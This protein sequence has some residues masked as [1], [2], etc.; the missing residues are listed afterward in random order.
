MVIVTRMFSSEDFL[1]NPFLS[2][3]HLLQQSN[4]RLKAVTNW[5]MC[6]DVSADLF[7]NLLE[8]LQSQDS[9]SQ[10]LLHTREE[11]VGLRS[12]IQQIGGGAE[13]GGS[14]WQSS[15]SA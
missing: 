3:M 14:C 1:V 9:A 10:H 6:V 12:Q 8:A 5:S 13:A 15:T 7:P 4:Y 11:E 2:Q